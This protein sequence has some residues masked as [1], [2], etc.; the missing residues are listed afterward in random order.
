MPQ[1]KR[2]GEILQAALEL[3]QQQLLTLIAIAAVL[4]AP[5]GS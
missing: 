4:V 3:H 1:P 5:A 2:P